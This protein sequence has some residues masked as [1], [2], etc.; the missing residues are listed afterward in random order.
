M[1]YQFQKLLSLLYYHWSIRQNSESKNHFIWN[2]K[3]FKIRT[4]TICNSS[5]NDGLKSVDIP[6]KLNSFTVWRVSKYGVFPGTP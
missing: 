1:F 3:H 5:E 4:T 6:Y 2:Q